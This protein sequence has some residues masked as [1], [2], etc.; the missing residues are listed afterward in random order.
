MGLSL[1]V[2]DVVGFE[3]GFMVGL[4]AARSELKLMEGGEDS[5][6]EAVGER[7]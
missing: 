7:D 3:E 5:R 4:M 6:A 2:E 1:G